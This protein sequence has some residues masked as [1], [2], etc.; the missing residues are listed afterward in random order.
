[1]SLSIG[2]EGGSGKSIIILYLVTLSVAKGLV[3]EKI[4]SSLRL[5]CWRL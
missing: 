5:K 3:P 1:M 4:D 2:E